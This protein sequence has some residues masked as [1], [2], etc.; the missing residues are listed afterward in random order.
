MVVARCWSAALASACLSSI[1][2]PSTTTSPARVDHRVVVGV[3]GPH[4]HPATRRP[5]PLP[6]P[7]TPAAAAFRPYPPPPPT[8]PTR[9]ARSRSRSQ[10]AQS[11]L[12]TSALRPP[13]KQRCTR[14]TQVDAISPPAVAARCVAPCRRSLLSTTGGGGRKRDRRV[15]S[16]VEVRTDTCIGW[17]KTLGSCSACIS[18]T[19]LRLFGPTQK[20]F[21][22]LQRKAPHKP[23]QPRP[24]APRTATPM[25]AQSA[26]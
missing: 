26:C 24:R 16:N 2:L 8:G 22:H 25:P 7:A 4:R 19:A 15:F 13:A 1:S 14:D 10:S 18:S 6:L 12:G 5:L 17:P 9:Q 11:A 21:L 23:H 20:V 3:G